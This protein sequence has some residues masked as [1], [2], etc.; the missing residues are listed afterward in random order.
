MI[1]LL[2]KGRRI[3]LDVDVD[4]EEVQGVDASRWVGGWR[5]RA[6]ANARQTPHCTMLEPSPT[7]AFDKK[8]Q[9]H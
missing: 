6:T 4:V 7:V 2:V 3:V 8:Q 1:S 9:L 5:A